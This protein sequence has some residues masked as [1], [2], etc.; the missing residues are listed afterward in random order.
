L[1]QRQLF[2]N[3]LIIAVHVDAHKAN[4][5][6]VGEQSNIFNLQGVETGGKQVVQMSAD[7]IQG[8]NT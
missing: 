2:G 3:G 1:V 8:P 7:S 4:I 6:A 5:L